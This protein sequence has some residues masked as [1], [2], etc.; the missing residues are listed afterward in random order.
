MFSLC[1]CVLENRI[2]ITMIR[3]VIFQ[4]WLSNL[5]WKQTIGDAV[6]IYRWNNFVSIYRRRET[7]F[8][9]CN[10]VMTWIFF[11]RIYRRKYRGIQTRI[12]DQWRVANTGGITNDY[13]DGNIP[14]VMP[15][16]NAGIYSLCRHSFFLCFS[17]FFP[18]FFPIPP[19][20]SQ[21]AANHPSQL[22]PL[23]NT[24]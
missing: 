20:P 12:V 9:S 19:L 5:F 2:L 14:L 1:F 10:G 6:G 3:I 11:R 7:F 18:F 15:S 23:L 24:S 4:F 16:V 22:S 13:T 17:F 8:E 21:T